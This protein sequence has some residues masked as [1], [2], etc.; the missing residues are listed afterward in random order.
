MHVHLYTSIQA[1]DVGLIS[2]VIH[3]YKSPIRFVALKFKFIVQCEP[4]VTEYCDLLL[5][6]EK[7]N[8]STENNADD[9]SI[10]Q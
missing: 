8:V 9:L 2:K 4:T 1:L 3:K 6:A 10:K 7:R 5:L